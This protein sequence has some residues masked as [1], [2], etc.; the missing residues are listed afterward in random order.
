MHRRRFITGTAGLAAA[1]QA[2]SLLRAQRA[3]DTITGRPA[4]TV[5]RDEDF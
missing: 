4:D 5:A 1:F 2:D 3:T